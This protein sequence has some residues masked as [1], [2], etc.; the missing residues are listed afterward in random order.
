MSEAE[1]VFGRQQGEVGTVMDGSMHA[2][3]KG[4]SPFPAGIGAKCCPIAWFSR[5][6]KNMNFYV[7]FFHFSTSSRSQ[8]KYV[9]TKSN[10]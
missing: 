6:T 1:W 3:P 7:T 9:C 2:L 8:A 5:E 4:D 10:L